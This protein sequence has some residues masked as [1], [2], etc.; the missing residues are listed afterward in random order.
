LRERT[1]SHAAGEP[2][3]PP[4]DIIIGMPFLL[5]SPDA[6][7]I[8]RNLPACVAGAALHPQV[9]PAGAVLDLQ[10]ERKHGRIS[11]E[12][13]L[14]LPRVAAG[15]GIERVEPN[16]TVGGL[17]DECEL[18][19]RI[20]VLA[21]NRVVQISWTSYPCRGRDTGRMNRNE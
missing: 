10:E 2:I 16:T 3:P 15:L 5:S 8:V 1:G 9:V 21:G 13:E 17:L 12:G 11:L 19:V 14:A 4:T 7:G 20:L 6:L 18:R